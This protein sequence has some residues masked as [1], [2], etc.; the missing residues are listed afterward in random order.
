MEHSGKGV[1]LLFDELMKSGDSKE[2]KDLIQEKVSEL[3]KCLDTLTTHFN[4]VMTTLNM[5]VT[6]KEIKSGRKIG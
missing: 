1:L 4:V 3:G 6:N 2:D 5:L